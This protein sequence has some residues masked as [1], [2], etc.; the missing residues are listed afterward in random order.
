MEMIMYAI[1]MI[2]ASM[3]VT[4]VLAPT[5]PS[6]DAATLNDFDFPQIDEG[7]PQPIVFGDV[8]VSGWTVLNVGNFRTSPISGQQAGKK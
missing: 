7:T 6:Q 4:S 8:W 5:P 1:V 3:V 2:A